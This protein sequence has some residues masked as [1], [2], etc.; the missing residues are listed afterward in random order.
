MSYLD[1]LDLDDLPAN[2]I[3][4]QSPPAVIASI[5]RRSPNVRHSAEQPNWQTPAEDIDCARIALG[6]RTDGAGGN[7]ALDPFSCLSGNLRVRADRYFGPDNNFD[8]FVMPW[9]AETVFINHPGKTTK[10]SWL[11]M[12]AELAAGHFRRAVW[13]GFSVEQLCILSEPT[14]LSA[15]DRWGCGAFVPTD[16]SICFLRKRIHFIDPDAPDRESRPGHANYILGIGT[17][18]DAFEQAYRHRGQIVHGALALLKG[19]NS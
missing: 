18:I 19:S 5:T 13:V 1:D 8:G 4:A 15:S 3:T 17:S 16:F 12:C 11:K 7:I 10:R 14:E 2:M 9:I 6:P